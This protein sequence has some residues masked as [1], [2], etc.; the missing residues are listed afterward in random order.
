ML[1]ATL[2][3]VAL[4]VK[5]LSCNKN[6]FFMVYDGNYFNCSTFGFW[7]DGFW[8]IGDFCEGI[9]VRWDYDTHHAEGLVNPK[10][11]TLKK[12]Y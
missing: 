8:Q 5:I 7:L 1:R 10:V 12:G 2:K 6:F 3:F 9:L 11:R 4:I